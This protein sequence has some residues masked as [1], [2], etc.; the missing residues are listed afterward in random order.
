[1]A[2]DVTVEAM[3]TAGADAASAVNAVSKSVRASSMRSR[4]A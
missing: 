3:M 1:V 2:V 4:V